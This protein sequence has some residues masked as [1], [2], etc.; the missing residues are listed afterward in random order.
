MQG[1]IVNL[2]IAVFSGLTLIALVA[3]LGTLFPRRI[4]TVHALAAQRPGQSF[5]IGLI[6]FLFFASIA[7]GFTVLGDRAGGF[8]FIP[9][10][11]VWAPIVI[12]VTFGVAGVVR[13][14]GERLYPERDGLR[15]TVYA[16]GTLYLACLTPFVGWF[17]LS[18]YTGI[19]G[20]GAVIL[21]FF[22]KGEEEGGMEE[23]EEDKEEEK[24]EDD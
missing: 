4:G 10:V 3:V 2:L 16:T 14:V 12:A 5:L 21:S 15:R 22:R 6:N 23:D 11:L 17:G 18:A 19:L 20:L 8:F 24:E 13:I 7:I 9:A 1:M